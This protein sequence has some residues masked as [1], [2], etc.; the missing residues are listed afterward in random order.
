[1][2]EWI[3]SLKP[4]DKVAVERNTIHGK[5]Y[6]IKDVK[7]ITPGGKVRLENEKLC[8]S[9]GSVVGGKIDRGNSTKIVPYDQK[10]KEHFRKN[11]VLHAISETNFQKLELGKLEA[12]LKI[13][14]GE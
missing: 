6:S 14:E 2:N 8:N 10:V 7:K 9:D 13:I 1:M 4:G 12:I 3:T 11:R 5:S